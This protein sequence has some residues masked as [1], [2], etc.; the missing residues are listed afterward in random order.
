MLR[1]LIA[2]IGSLVLDIVEILWNYSNEM[3]LLAQKYFEAQDTLWIEQEKLNRLINAPTA[4][5]LDQMRF[6]IAI[7]LDI[8]K[9][10]HIWK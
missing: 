9:Q 6:Y 2:E 8:Q 4:L 7:M 1:L 3:L 10:S 5:I